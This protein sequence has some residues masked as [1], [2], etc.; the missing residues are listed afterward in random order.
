MCVLP[1]EHK[2]HVGQSVTLPLADSECHSPN[3]ER[4][5]LSARWQ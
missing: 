5:S 3:S 2:K 1:N 4:H